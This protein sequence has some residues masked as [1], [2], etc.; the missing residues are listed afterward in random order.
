[1]AADGTTAE[2][3]VRNYFAGDGQVGTSAAG[4]AEEAID[5]L[6]RQ[7]DAGRATFSRW[8]DEDLHR[9]LRDCGLDETNP[10]SDSSLLSLLLHVVDEQIHHM[11]EVGLLR[12]L[13]RAGSPKPG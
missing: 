10:Y 6:T 13:Y 12:D 5:I 1:M 8:S 4:G 2:E 3:Y 9:S 7:Y 11:S